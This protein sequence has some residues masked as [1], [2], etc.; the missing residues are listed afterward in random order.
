MLLKNLFALSFLV[1]LSSC[2]TAPK[3]DPCLQRQGAFDMGSGSTKALGAVVDI[4]R[5]RVVEVFFDRQ[6]PVPFNETLERSMDGRLPQALFDQ[7]EKPLREL[8]DELRSQKLVK[9]SGV[10]T[11]VF[12]NAQ[13]GT[14]FV[15]EI[16]QR[17]GIPIRVIS[18]EEEARL[19]YWS[20]LSR[21]PVGDGDEVIVWD[22]GGGSMQISQRDSAGDFQFFRG[23][24][25][26]VS[27]KNR[28][29]KEVLKKDPAS[30]HS[31][32][33]LGRHFVP[34]LRLARDH[35]RKNVPT[36]LR[37]QERTA[38]WLG[39]GGVLSRSLPEQVGT[40]GP[41]KAQQIRKALDERAQWTDAQIGG[42]Y[43][44]TDVTNLI[45]VLAYMDVLKIS[46]IE[47]V[48]VALGLGLMLEESRPREPAN[49]VGWDS[50]LEIPPSLVDEETQQIGA[51]HLARA[52]R[53]PA[54]NRVLV[55]FGGTNS[56][57]HS[58]GAFAD[59]AS[60]QGYHVLSLDYPN[61]VIS[62]ICRE[63]PA[64]DCADRFREEILE[65][66]DVSPHVQVDSK[67]AI[68]YRLRTTMKWLSQIDPTW[69][70][71]WAG[72]DL[73]W[74]KV[75]V[76]GHSQG[77]GHAAYLS[78]RFSLQG[79]ILFAG[80]QDTWNNQPAAWLLRPGLTVGDRYH[81]LLHRRD[82]FGSEGQILAVQT[83]RRTARSP[84]GGGSGKPVTIV[85]EADVHDPHNAILNPAFEADWELMLKAALP[86]SN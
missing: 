70:R 22:I 35:A 5:Q 2:A 26:S 27:F 85:S 20:A 47:P 29:I 28:V 17:I 81:A 15:Q 7:I 11:A 79:V 37:D 19:G 57:P 59:L 8:A 31:P 39:I 33:P 71:F 13:N 14:E 46:Q 64:P 38:V 24:L 9:V 63:H 58:F 34:A 66:R 65:G 3:P 43:A 60:V 78:K 42:S 4:C 69:A 45:L 54:V 76:A 50:P 40:Q 32:N 53:G 18:Q 55:T 86:V 10:A 48:P 30:V 41:I 61:R 51:P 16:S 36:R 75:V 68:L 77:A 73:R 74:D 44:A 72:D 23:D 80:P 6:I 83:L 21:R 1:F 84:V 25:A 82:F 62:T 52:P 56:S 49:V 67:N 12:R